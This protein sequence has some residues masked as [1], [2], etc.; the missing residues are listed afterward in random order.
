MILRKR[1]CVNWLGTWNVRGI[2]GTAKRE[3]LVD[4]FR[5]G[6]FKFLA[7]TETKLKGNGEGSWCEEIERDREGMAILLNNVQHTKVRD[8][9]CVKSRILW[10]KFRFS[11]VKV[12]VVVRCGRTKGKVKKGRGSRM[13]WT[14]L[15]IE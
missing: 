14:G 5:K 6:K 15:W 8:C 2:N 1:E 7:L 9:R 4:V 3:K 11:R 12:S 13:T 10:I